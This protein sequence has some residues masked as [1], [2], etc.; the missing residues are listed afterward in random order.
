MSLDPSRLAASFADAARDLQAITLDVL[1]D[2]GD[3]LVNE[4]QRDWPRRT[5]RSAGSFSS[6]RVGDTVIFDNRVPYVPHVHRAGT[7][8][9]ALD[10]ITTPAIVRAFRTF[11]DAVARE[12]TRRTA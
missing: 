4:M 9:L 8:T 1:E 12:V 3:Q 6:K 2:V 7:R 10:E 5:G 11:P